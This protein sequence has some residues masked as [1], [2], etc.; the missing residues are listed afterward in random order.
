MMTLWQGLSHLP[1]SWHPAI[2][3]LCGN[4][5]FILAKS[6]KKIAQANIEACF[7]NLSK[8]E[9]QDLL[10]DNFL[11]LG[12]SFIETGIAWFWLDKKIQSK[13]SPPRGF[14]RPPRGFKTKKNERAPGGCR[15]SFSF[16][17]GGSKSTLSRLKVT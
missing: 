15:F 2:G 12:R 3:R 5:L 7:P 13:R 17:V 6:R 16:Y 4:L 1:T 14:K 11:H 9:R 8:A 10:Q